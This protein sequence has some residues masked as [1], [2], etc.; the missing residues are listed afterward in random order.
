MGQGWELKGEQA[1]L[2]AWSV[3]GS[4]ILTLRS[5]LFCDSLSSGHSGQAGHGVLP[6]PFLHGKLSAAFTAWF[7]CHQMY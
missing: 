6:A 1:T 7:S 4:V 5:S 3:R 2:G